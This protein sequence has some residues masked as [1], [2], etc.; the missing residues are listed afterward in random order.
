MRIE[1]SLDLEKR[2][3]T[4]TI[5]TDDESFKMTFE[6]DKVSQELKALSTNLIAQKILNILGFKIEIEKKA[7]P[8]EKSP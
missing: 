6:L 1:T 2:T 7:K 3:A 5:H 4:V 8:S